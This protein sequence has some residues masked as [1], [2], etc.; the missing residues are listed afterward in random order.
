MRYVLDAAAAKKVDEISI[1][2]YGIPSIVLMERAALAVADA[3]ERY[4]SHS[5]KQVRILVVCGNGNNGAD[6]I[7]AARILFQRGFDVSLYLMKKSGTQ[8]FDT[9]LAIAGKL[10]LPVCSKADFAEYTIIVDALFGIGLSRPVEGTYA[11]AVQNINRSSAWKLSVDV[12][13]GIDASSGK[14]LGCAVKAHKTVTFG[15]AKT[16]LLFYPGAD[17]AG[18]IKVCDAGFVDAAADSIKNKAFVYDKGD[19]ARLPQRKKDSHKGTYG[20]ILVIAGSENMCGAALLAGLSAYRSGAGLVK[21]FTHSNNRNAIN[22]NVP[23]ALLE[24]YDSGEIT[25][26]LE[27]SME[28]ATFIIMG[29][30]LSTGR[31]AQKIAEYVF[32]NR[33]VPLLADAD[34]LNILAQNRTIR[35]SFLN[36]ANAECI[37]TP[38]LAEMAR[39]C[40]ETVMDVKQD[41]AGTALRM[42]KKLGAIC[43]LKDVRTIVCTPSSKEYYINTSGCDGMA[44]GGSGDVLTGVIAGLAANGMPAYEAACMGVYLH[45]LGGEA[46]QKKFGGYGMKA[47]DIIEG[48][49]HVMNKKRG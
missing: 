22:K 33:K 25:S 13:S 23:E 48:V 12:P 19:L 34:A 38:H 29:P 31:D 27:K 42:A 43:V 47:G 18:K 30:G 10:K 6:G 7:A 32:A 40:D 5:A 17:F 11:K 35:Q 39:L 28:W 3:V 46:A 21:I 1:H 41:I 24:T 2:K 49:V 26:K 8:E 20:K 9:Q 14:I 4:A 44:T 37:I 45:G 36:N 16:G 15:Y